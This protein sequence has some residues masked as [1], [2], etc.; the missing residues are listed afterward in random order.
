MVT[1][2]PSHLLILVGFVNADVLAIRDHEN[3]G[4]AHAVIYQCNERNIELEVLHTDV[5]AEACAEGSLRSMTTAL[6]LSAAATSDI[7][8][9]RLPGSVDETAFDVHTTPSR[10]EGGQS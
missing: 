4:H 5:C 9:Q 8:E 6:L 1:A 2:R 10:M 7:Y 3:D